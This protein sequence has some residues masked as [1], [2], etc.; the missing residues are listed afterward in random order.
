VGLY[1]YDRTS[2]AARL[3]KRMRAKEEGKNTLLPLV[4]GDGKKSDGLGS[5]FVQS[6]GGVSPLG[7][8]G[9]PSPANG[10][11]WLPPGTKADATWTTEDVARHQSVD[12]R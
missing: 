12:A 4:N 8:N 7:M 9:R 11:M 3:D 1:L 6:P 5:V 10:D 2:D